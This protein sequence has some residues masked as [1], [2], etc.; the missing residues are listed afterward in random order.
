MELVKMETVNKI[1]EVIS[2]IDEYKNEPDF[3]AAIKN[4]EGRNP[5]LRISDSDMLR[6]IASLIAYSRQVH[7][8]A[9]EA[10]LKYKTFDKVFQNFDIEKVANMDPN[11][12]LNTHW[13]KKNECMV[14]NVEWNQL[15]VIRQKTKINDVI[16]CAK[17]IRSIQS[18]FGSFFDFLH[19]YSLPIDLKKESDIADFWI[20]FKKI[21][22][23]LKQVDMATFGET[24]TLL[25]LLLHLGYPCIKSDSVVM[26]VS[27]DLW[28]A[29]SLI[30]TVRMIQMFCLQTGT[31]PAVVD[32]YFL[33]WGGQD[34]QKKLVKPEFYKNKHSNLTQQLV[35]SAESIKQFVNSLPDTHIKEHLVIESD[36]LNRLL[37]LSKER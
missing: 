37:L 33:I 32:L 36:R 24:T 26:K 30:Q 12:I 9:V 18:E 35:Y 27:K 11:E 28:D 6:E 34:A 25:H 1:N 10:M 15:T 29:Q 19:T 31:K 7:S 16:K 22:L 21:K 3:T 8:R 4:R 14:N 23:K 13:I 17:A 20:Y 5:N 2:T